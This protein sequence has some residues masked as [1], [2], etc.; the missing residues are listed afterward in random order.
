M[1]QSMIFIDLSFSV[2]KSGAILIFFNCVMEMHVEYV[3]VQIATCIKFGL[4]LS[5]SQI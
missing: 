3:M 4:G 2:E 5:A 1:L